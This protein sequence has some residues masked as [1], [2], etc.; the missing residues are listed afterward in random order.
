MIR[1]FKGCNRWLSNF[2]PCTVVLD[3]IAYPSTENAYQAAK[4][5]IPAERK[6]FENITAWQAKRAGR[7]VTLRPGW[8]NIKISI[9]ENLNQQKYSTEPMR[10]KLIATG[11]VEIQEV[12]TWNDT[13][14]GVC[15]GVGYN[16]L[17]LIIMR[18]RA[19]INRYYV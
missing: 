11:D 9:M 4:T 13:F 3:G 5:V 14:W 10:S 17:G 8:N 16:H 1:E 19:E 6:Q 7:Q 18:I 15:N 12:N 2:A